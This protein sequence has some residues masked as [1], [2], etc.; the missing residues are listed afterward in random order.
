MAIFHQL[1]LAMP[2]T[3]EPTASQA[4]AYSRL[5]GR[6]PVPIWRNFLQADLWG[7]FG[8]ADSPIGCCSGLLTAWRFTTRNR[9]S[10]GL[11][12]FPTDGEEKEENDES[13]SE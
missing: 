12:H 4:R 10:S 8:K 7:I 11:R 3:T 1:S 13:Y 6:F 2:S 9:I 5:Q